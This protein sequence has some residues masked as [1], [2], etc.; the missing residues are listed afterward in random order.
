[1]NLHPIFVHFPIALLTLYSLAEFLRFKALRNRAWWF[2]V[3]AALVVPGALAAGAAYLTGNMAAEGTGANSALRQALRAHENWAQATIIIYGA[4]AAV[5]LMAFLLRDGF[6]KQDGGYASKLAE[7]AERV[8]NSRLVPIFVL[9]GLLAVTIT[10]A[11]G[12]SI[13]YGPDVD[14]VV[15]LVY[16]LLG[17]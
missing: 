8:L 11:L 10:G 14:P 13:V 2:Y 7:A 4:V 1:M 16:Q 5:Y 9:L 15:K 6:I 3:K 17:L 12:G